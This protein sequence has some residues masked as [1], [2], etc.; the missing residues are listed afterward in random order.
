MYVCLDEQQ[1][2]MIQA[3]IRRLRA[4]NLLYTV[5]PLTMDIPELDKEAI[6]TRMKSNN[7]KK[8]RQGIQDE[9]N[10]DGKRLMLGPQAFLK[11]WLPLTGFIE[12]LKSI[13]SNAFIR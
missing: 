1:V 4:S 9:K 5:V 11:K 2:E 8:I 13:I 7:G 10:Q 12:S 3:G 6:K